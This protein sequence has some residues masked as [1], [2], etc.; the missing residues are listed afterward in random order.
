VQLIPAV[1]RNAR[2][3]DVLM[4]AWMNEES[5]RLSI[6]TG[7]TWFWSRSR[8]ELW[9]KGATSGNRQRIVSIRKDCDGDALL[10]DVEPAGPACHTGATSCFDETVTQV[11]DIK[12]PPALIDTLKQRRSEKPEGSY[13][14]KL[15]ARG[16]NAILKKIGEEATEVV[17]AATSELRERLVSEI[18]DLA[19]HVLVLMVEREIEPDEIARELESRVGKRRAD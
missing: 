17:I 2:T 16:Q 18:A 4:L 1:I 8:Q 3:H 7:E 9:N 15:F 12:F 10:I 19:F 6:E 11:S 13:T 5:L 14:A